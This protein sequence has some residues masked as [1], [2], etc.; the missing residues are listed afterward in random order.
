MEPRWV[1]RR[2]APGDAEEARSHVA[3]DPDEER[4]ARSKREWLARQTDAGRRQAGV[5]DPVG[6]RVDGQLDDRAGPDRGPHCRA[7]SPAQPGGRQS[8][9][10]DD[11]K[12]VRSAPSE[13][14][15][16]PLARHG[17]AKR[18]ARR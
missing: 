9:D 14:P 16:G 3:A 17:R 5:E 2:P 12:P 4:A 7:A 1:T 13:P 8:M 18:P 11:P 15:E 10:G 6:P